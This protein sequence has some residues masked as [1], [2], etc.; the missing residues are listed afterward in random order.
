MGRVTAR[1][2]ETKK[3]RISPVFMA[4][5]L[6][7]SLTGLIKATSDISAKEALSNLPQELDEKEKDAYESGIRRGIRF[8]MLK[9]ISDFTRHLIIQNK[10]IMENLNR[11]GIKLSRV[12]KQ[13][14][15]ITGLL[16]VNLKEDSALEDFFLHFVYGQQSKLSK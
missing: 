9:E 10:Q 11:N 7:E 13:L 3:D 6:V 16:E 14:E 1:Q 2:A 15:K 4:Y 5:G 12:I 8:G